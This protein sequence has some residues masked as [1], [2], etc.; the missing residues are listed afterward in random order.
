MFPFSR[1]SLRWRLAALYA[2]VIAVAL[3]VVLAV[4]QA[5]V[6]RSLIES[7][8]QRLEL[9]AGLIANQDAS[10][11]SATTLAA[12]ELVRVLG[13]QATAVVI[14]DSSGA[15]LAAEANGAPEWVVDARLETSEYEQVIEQRQILNRVTIPDGG[16]SERVLVVAAP[17]RFEPEA[18]PSPGASAAASPTATRAPGPPFTPPGRGRGQGQGQGV[19]IGL[20]NGQGSGSSANPDAEIVLP[21][22]ALTQLA[23]SL[24]PVDA[25]LAG[26]RTT[27]IFIGFVGFLLAFVMA[28]TVTSLGLRP[29]RQVAAAADRVARGDLAARAELPSGGDEIGRLGRSFD[30][31]TERVEAA[32][33]AQ[34]QFAA[35]A[36][37]E[38]RSPLT[39]L[40][41]YVDV[42]KTG[43][44]DTPETASRI[45]GSMRRE[46]DRLS[47]LAADLLLLTQLEAGGGR[48]APVALD[49]GDLLDDLV[50]AARVMGGDHPI[51]VV[52]DAQL[53]VLA[54]R[55]RLMQALL[56][57]VD[58][59]V[60]HARPGGLVRLSGRRDGTS[61]VLEVFDEG[62]PIRP[63]DLPRLFDRFF[64]AD[65]TREAGR[66]AGL[67]LAITKAIV[68]ASGGSIAA[69][70]VSDGTRFTIRLPWM[71]T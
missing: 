59:A 64:R 28:L 35:D 46:I 66:H 67:G 11:V 55:D 7:T 41:G 19:G 36:S 43:A 26:L 50:E 15:T 56:N 53:M 16:G 38:L 57:L 4:V 51:E 65:G 3:V 71:A 45:L 10:G 13:G 68:E 33:G 21:P 9:E 58:N 39:V 61:I 40:G 52:R 49:A 42:L 34:R 1:I 54:D 63:D 48:L 60:R 47:R 30:R 70:S 24:A 20:G 18:T 12:T 6:E 44:L 27:L 37:H 23:V 17:I 14:L 2:A 5:L 62:D 8:A 32:F 22:N 29:L 69:S 25:T 31:M